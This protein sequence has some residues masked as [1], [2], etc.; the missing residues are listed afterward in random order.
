MKPVLIP[1]GILLVVFGVMGVALFAITQTAN[2]KPLMQ[3][4]DFDFQGLRLGDPVPGRLLTKLK[5]PK[6]DLVIE[7]LKDIKTSVWYTV[8]DG[9]VEALSLDF[10][11]VYQAIEAYETKFGVKATIRE[12]DA[13]WMTKNGEFVISKKRS[14]GRIS[15]AKYTEHA[16]ESVKQ[17]RDDLS[18]KL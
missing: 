6:E 9:N 14:S 18:K 2:K 16:I 11:N 10:D 15:S 13:A 3:V 7:W 12:E 1:A 4:V 5:N 8:L 17:N